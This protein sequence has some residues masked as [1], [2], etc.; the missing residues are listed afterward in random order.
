MTPN[1]QSTFDENVDQR[2][3]SNRADALG[4]TNGLEH[5]LDG[6]EIEKSCSN[7]RKYLKKTR[8]FEK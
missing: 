2:N 7:W 6:Q 3:Q 8:D 5:H 1:I 4:V